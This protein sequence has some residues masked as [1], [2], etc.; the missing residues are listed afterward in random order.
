MKGL[1]V[2]TFVQNLE[3]FENLEL[4]DLEEIIRRAERVHTWLGETGGDL[5][6]KVKLL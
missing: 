6:L 2:A 5:I 1:R 3:A 4:G